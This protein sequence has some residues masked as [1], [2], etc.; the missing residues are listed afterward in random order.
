MKERG[1]VKKNTKNK[2]NTKT[3]KP[4]NQIPNEKEAKTNKNQKKQNNNNNKILGLSMLT[5]IA[6]PP[7]LAWER[8]YETLQW[9][10]HTHRVE[11]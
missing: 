6:R 8:E 7:L 4:T 11:V 9:Q 3:Q 10:G 1:Y 5:K 2:K